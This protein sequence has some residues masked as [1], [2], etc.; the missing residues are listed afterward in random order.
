MTRFLS[1]RGESDDA[2]ENTLSAYKLAMERDSDGIELD[3]RLTADGEAAC[4][5]DETIERVSGVRLAV[6][7]ATLAALRQYHPVPLLSEALAVLKPGKQMQIELKGPWPQ[8]QPVKAVLDRRGGDRKG[9]ALSSFDEET[10]RAA[11]DVFPELPR[12]LLTDLTRRFGRFP[13]PEQVVACLH[14]LRCTGISFLATAEADAAFV[15]ALHRAGMRVVC[16][17]V[18]SDE[19]G[20]AMARIGV[21]AMTCN[22]AVALRAEYRKRIAG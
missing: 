5:H 11:A 8:L 1:H 9:L 2:P 15:E 17:G 18:R 21:D 7:D 6:S 14:S 20:L 13:A 16:W 3:I 12:L 22:H 4:V 10:I 19:L